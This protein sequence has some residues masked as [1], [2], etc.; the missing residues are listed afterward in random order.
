MTQ[1]LGWIATILFTICYVPQIVK[2]IR[3][4]NIDGVSIWMFIV[5]FIGNIIALVYAT[6]ISQP[7]II[8]KYAAALVLL[9][10]VFVTLLFVWIHDET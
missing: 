7:P 4:R 2:T 1:L 9:A 6:L 3:T 5:Q 10:I 8:F